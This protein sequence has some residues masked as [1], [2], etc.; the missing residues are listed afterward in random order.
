MNIKREYL[1]F[2]EDLNRYWES[3]KGLERYLLEPEDIVM[4]MDGSLVG[5]SFAM[6]SEDHLPLLLVQRVARIRSTEADIHYLYYC[7]CN[8]FFN[9]VN[10]KKTAGA[11]PHISQKDIANYPIPVPPK[12]DQLRI[13]S[14]LDKFEALVNDALPKEIAARH[15]QYEYYRDKLLSFERKK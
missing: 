13:V 14:I 7:I 1:D 9:Y 15:Q 12:E 10:N 11:I 4:S 8:G 3:E 6:V 2:S 5:K